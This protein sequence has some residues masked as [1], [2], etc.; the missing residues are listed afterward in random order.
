MSLVPFSFIVSVMVLEVI[1]YSSVHKSLKILGENSW[2]CVGMMHCF[3]LP[4][5]R[6]LEF[7][8][9]LFQT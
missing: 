4:F 7:T 6:T 1:L 5:L 9:I 3:A 2:Q 8:E